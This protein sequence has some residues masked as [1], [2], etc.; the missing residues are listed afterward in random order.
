MASNDFDVAQLATYL[1]M[2]PDQ[3]TKLASRGRLPARRIAGE[4]RFPKSEIH[5]WLEEKIGTGDAEQLT[6]VERLLI[7]TAGVDEESLRLVDIMPIEAIMIP[8]PSRTRTSVIRDMCDVAATTGLLWDP[9]AMAEAVQAR[10]V[11]H[12]TALENGVALLHPTRPQA[13][14]LAEPLVALGITS[15]PIPFSN[16]AGHLTDVFFL[17]CSTDD[18]I[19]LRLLARLSRLITDADWLMQLRQSADATAALELIRVAEAE[20]VTGNH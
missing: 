7:R 4:W 19:H 16:S 13:S 9:D 1:H 14:I 20:I 6:E 11:L 2:T 3:V 10:E 18:R 12:T 8:L 5:H 17:I 15:S